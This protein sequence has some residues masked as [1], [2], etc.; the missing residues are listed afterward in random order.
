MRRRGDSRPAGIR[1]EICRINAA[2]SPRVNAPSDQLAADGRHPGTAAPTPD[3]CYSLH[4]SDRST[5]RFPQA[6]PE[7]QFASD[8]VRVQ[9][10]PPG[11]CVCGFPTIT[12]LRE[13][14][15]RRFHHLD[16]PRV[17]RA[18]LSG[19][20]GRIGSLE[21][22]RMPV[23]SQPLKRMNDS[24]MRPS[25]LN[26]PSGNDD[27]CNSHTGQGVASNV[28]RCTQPRVGKPNAKQ[29]ATTMD[30]AAMTTTD[31]E[32]VLYETCSKILTG[33]EVDNLG[34][35]CQA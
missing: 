34:D 13:M 30:T 17:P 28:H 10:P 33:S 35:K 3:S 20:N 29:P 9:F 27:A 1:E 16:Q 18:D 2:C 8:E 31:D 19:R 25:R 26:A 12:V 21:R 15:P 24:S 6:F 22:F 11:T 4:V 23:N 32:R 5:R 14:R 7:K